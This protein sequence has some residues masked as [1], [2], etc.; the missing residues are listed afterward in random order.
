MSPYIFTVC[1]LMNIMIILMGNFERHYQNFCYLIGSWCISDITDP[2]QGE[3]SISQQPK[4][5]VTS[6]ETKPALTGKFWT[7]ICNINFLV[8]SWFC[9]C[10]ALYVVLIYSIVC[11]DSVFGV[12]YQLNCVLLD[13]NKSRQRSITYRGVELHCKIPRIYIYLYI[14]IVRDMYSKF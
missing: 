6:G 4:P 1:A 8:V 12:P 7:I 9:M 2:C 3:N 13:K 10:R 14:Y 11:Q 5:T